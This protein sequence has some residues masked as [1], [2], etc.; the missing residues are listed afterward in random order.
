MTFSVTVPLIF[1]TVFHWISVTGQLVL[2]VT[3]GPACLHTPTLWSVLGLQTHATMPG[4]VCGCWI[5]GNSAYT[6]NPLPAE[7]D[8]FSLV[9]SISSDIFIC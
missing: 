5:L 7:P 1:E 9:E 4:F 3:P 2:P 6:A 8:L